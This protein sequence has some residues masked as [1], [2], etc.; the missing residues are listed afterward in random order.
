VKSKVTMARSKHF[1]ASQAFHC[2]N[3]PKSKEEFRRI[4]K[5]PKW[6]LLVWNDRMTGGDGFVQDYD[7]MLKE[8]E[9]CRTSTHKNFR[10]EDIQEF[11]DNS[12]IKVGQ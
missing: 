6:V 5:E 1:P 3:R 4:S 7:S 12:D 11:V 2:F 9:S 10:L 8:F